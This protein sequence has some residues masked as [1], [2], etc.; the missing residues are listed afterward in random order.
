MPDGKTA[1]TFETS[2]QWH[3]LLLSC[4]SLKFSVLHPHRT[5]SGGPF[6]RCSSCH[7]EGQAREAA[8]D[9]HVT[10]PTPP[11]LSSSAAA[12]LTKLFPFISFWKNATTTTAAAP[13]PMRGRPRG[14]GKAREQTRGQWP[15][16]TA[17]TWR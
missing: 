17:A 13:R 15:N 2:L 5:S 6:I 12:A 8:A 10:P 1:R 11:L 9:R 14:T 16:M 4:L 3:Q 7:N